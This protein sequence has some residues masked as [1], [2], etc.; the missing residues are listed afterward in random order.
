[1]SVMARALGPIGASGKGVVERLARANH[2][3]EQTR[4]RERGCYGPT[5]PRIFGSKPAPYEFEDTVDTLV[6]CDID[7]L[8]LVDRDVDFVT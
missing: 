4:L 6:K 3:V 5:V 8:V 7:T 1:M 2:K